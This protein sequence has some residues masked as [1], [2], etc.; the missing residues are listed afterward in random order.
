MDIT[1][2]TD[3][4]IIGA[5]KTGSTTLYDYLQG[6]AD[7]ALCSPKEPGFFSRDERFFKGWKWYASLFESKG[8]NCLYG[9]ASTCY[10]R[11]LT[12][13]NTIKRIHQHNPRAKFIYVVRDP[14]QRAISHYKHRMEENRLNGLPIIPLSVLIKNDNELLEAGDYALQLKMY[15][16][17]FTKDQFL[18]LT[19]QELTQTPLMA[20]KKVS[21]FLGVKITTS[22]TMRSNTSGQSYQKNT[23]TN[24]FRSIRY[25]PIV[26]KVV[27]ILPVK[28]RAMTMDFLV[29]FTSNS[30]IGT[31]V[32]RMHT[33][34]LPKIKDEDIAFLDNY[35]HRSILNLQRLTGITLQP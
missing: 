11:N 29:R 24:F 9:D 27:D 12:Y 5:M 23:L 13:P 3:F 31:K 18:I 22:T 35:Y 8:K 15:F 19:F 33:Q 28:S 6:H 16:E 2:T 25:L 10:S 1:H 34:K 4:F 26:T 20:L 30:F 21:E 17:F 14:V 32:N 7:I